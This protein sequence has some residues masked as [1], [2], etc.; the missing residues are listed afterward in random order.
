[1][2]SSS[3]RSNKMKKWIYSF[4]LL[5]AVN[6]YAQIYI[7]QESNG[8]IIYSDVPIADTEKTANLPPQKPQAISTEQVSQKSGK[9]NKIMTAQNAEKNS[10]VMTTKVVEKNNRTMFSKDVYKSLRIISP[11]DHETYKTKP[12]IHVALQVKPALQKNDKIQLFI[13]GKSVGKPNTS[14]KIDTG[15]MARGPHEMYALI[16][17]QTKNFKIQSN[18]INFYVM[19]AHPGVPI[20]SNTPKMQ[21]NAKKISVQPTKRPK[22]FL[23]NQKIQPL[24]RPKAFH[25]NNHKNQPIKRPTTFHANNHKT[26]SIKRPTTFLAR[27]R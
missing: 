3:T 16:I 14:L 23:A 7:K 8:D 17:D 20:S 21:P 27:N 12:N 18:I 4:L 13:D 19:R 22:A 6:T 9:N 10:M 11:M 5:F 24:K 15:L 1:M 2:D 26:Q 25:A